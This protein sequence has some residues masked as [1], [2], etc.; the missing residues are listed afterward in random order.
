MLEFAFSRRDVLL[1]SSQTAS[2]QRGG[3]PPHLSY[4]D[5]SA[6]HGAFGIHL[7]R[8]EEEAACGRRNH[9]IAGKRWAEPK[10][11][12][13][14]CLPG[15]V[16][17]TS[18][19]KSGSDATITLRSQPGDQF[20]VI[21]GFRP[22]VPTR[23]A[24]ARRRH[25]QVIEHF[26]GVI[27]DDVEA[28]GIAPGGHHVQVVCGWTSAATKKRLA[29][30]SLLTRLAIAIASAAAVA[31]IKQRSGSDIQ[32]GQIPQSDLLEV[33][34]RLQTAAPGYF[35]RV[36]GIGGIPARVFPACCAE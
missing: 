30:F 12:S 32:P 35:R 33:E 31:S 27:D 22:V 23:A 4:A 16:S 13:A 1:A 34:Q 25:P 17:S 19:I 21:V 10:T 24:A 28:E 2:V 20:A 29:L 5:N 6:R 9:H 8:R 15:A 14:P 7:F 36:A 18:A 11:I 26:V 3:S